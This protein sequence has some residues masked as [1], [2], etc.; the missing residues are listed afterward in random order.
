MP[1][2]F[3]F[4]LEKNRFAN[5]RVHPCTVGVTQTR[6]KDS[7]CGGG[8]VMAATILVNMYVSLFCAPFCLREPAENLPV[9]IPLLFHFFGGLDATANI[10]EINYKCF[11]GLP[12]R[13]SYKAGVVNVASINK[14]PF[15]EPG[16]QRPP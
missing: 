10:V 5:K 13:Q 1:K 4:Q 9:W 7:L 3:W 11:Q 8:V 16:P 6:K 14:R 15:Q 12:S 2:V